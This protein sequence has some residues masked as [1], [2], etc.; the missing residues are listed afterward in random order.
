MM[1]TELSPNTSDRLRSYKLRELLQEELPEPVWI[2]P[3]LLPQGVTLLLG[4]VGTGKSTLAL[5][6]ALAVACSEPTPDD[7][8]RGH[9]PVLYIDLEG[10]ERCM[11]D[12]LSKVLKEDEKAPEGA[13]WIGGWNPLIKGGLADLEDWFEQHSETR[14]LIID[15]LASLYSF[16]GGRRRNAE[17]V[18]MPLMTLAN[19]YHA[20]IL[21][22]LHVCSG[23][24]E[25][26]KRTAQMERLTDCIMMIE[27]AQGTSTIDI[28]GWQLTAHTVSLHSALSCLQRVR[29]H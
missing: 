5:Q 11:R 27:Q 17:S 1:S 3:D 22:L 16:P 24:A 25:K 8:S 26:E 14:L 20:A 23:N 15:T 19:T 12:R 13:Y 4:E 29:E 9:A 2:I 6:M 10:G 18:F 28:T 21:L 7:D